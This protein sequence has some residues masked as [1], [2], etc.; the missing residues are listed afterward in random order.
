MGSKVVNEDVEMPVG[1]W[2]IYPY[3]RNVIRWGEV[4]S[5]IKRWNIS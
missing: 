5:N 2:R 3:S 1:M 4:A